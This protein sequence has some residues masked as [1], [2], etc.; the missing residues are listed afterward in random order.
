MD[1]TPNRLISAPLWRDLIW[2]MIIL[3][4]SKS[5]RGAWY[6][7]KLTNNSWILRVFSRF[8]NQ[9]ITKVP[10]K[11]STSL[12]AKKTSNSRL[13]QLVIRRQQY[14]LGNLMLSQ[15]QCTSQ[16]P[17]T[18][19]PF[20]PMKLTKSTMHLS[21]KWAPETKIRVSLSHLMP[22]IFLSKFLH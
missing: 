12:S 11:K 16:V 19:K 15:R 21:F 2:T 9:Q 18:S 10:N 4:L 14:L 1:F 3:L 6:S 7:L 22:R 20:L 13:S 5:S 17:N 8:T